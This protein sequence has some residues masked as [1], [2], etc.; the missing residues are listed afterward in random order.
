MD[1]REE[2]GHVSPEPGDKQA[3]VA[4]GFDDVPRIVRR[5]LHSEVL[6]KLRDMIIE[7]RLA[8][9]ARINEG[10]IGAIL[11]V[12]RTPLREAIK[13]LT[14]EGLV[15]IVPAKGAVVRRFTEHDLVQILQVLKV[16]EQLGARLTCEH[17]SDEA[18]RKIKDIHDRMM[19][20][21][22]A[23]KRL[24]YFKLNQ[25]IHTSFVQAS[26]NIFL[27]EMHETLQARIKRPRY[28]GNSDPSKWANAVA[29]HEDM[30][31]ALMKR[32]GEK[33]AD[34]IGRHLDA[35]VLRVR[36]VL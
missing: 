16:I 11:G 28:V 23:G 12:S 33:L 1:L 10:Q 31:E 14:S 17:A 25:A 19:K 5:T 27:A 7:G 29:E 13:S 32:D 20:L 24:E 35:T 34:A 8:P 9:G 6:N 30:I 26:G 15:E 22:K 36:N 4:T 21:Y 2:R 18:I 3:A